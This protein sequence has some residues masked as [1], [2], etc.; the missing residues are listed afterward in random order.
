M[1]GHPETPN[2]FEQA[3]CAY[4]RILEKPEDFVNVNIAGA[5]LKRL[6]PEQ[7]KEIIE[8]GDRLARIETQS[9]LGET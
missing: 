7:K 3:R 5:L 1:I 9:S 4:L 6:S 8:E 2:L